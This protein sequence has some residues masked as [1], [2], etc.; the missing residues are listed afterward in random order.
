M[1]QAGPQDSN[2]FPTTFYEVY[3]DSDIITA[4]YFSEPGCPHSQVYG[5][6]GNWSIGRNRG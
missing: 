2:L 3:I 1:L 5:V 6:F 4:H